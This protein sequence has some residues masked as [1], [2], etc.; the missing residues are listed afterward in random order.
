MRADAE[1]R[2][3]TRDF[4]GALMLEPKVMVADEPVDGLPHLV[5]DTLMAEPGARRRV[6]EETLRFAESLR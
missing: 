6:A 2:V 3:L 1:S 4:E 5:T